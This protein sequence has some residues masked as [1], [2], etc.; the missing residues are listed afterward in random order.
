[1]NHPTKREKIGKSDHCEAIFRI[2]DMIFFVGAH[3]SIYFVNIKLF[4]PPPQYPPH[5]K[6]KKA[7]IGKSDNF[8]D[9]FRSR[10][11]N[12]FVGAHTLIY[13]VNLR[14]IAPISTLTT[15]QK[16]KKRKE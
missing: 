15:P 6:G 12:F 3:N 16:G 9:I 13:F 1:M 8:E 5:K 4:S 10:D 7:K 14:H 11:R 2:R